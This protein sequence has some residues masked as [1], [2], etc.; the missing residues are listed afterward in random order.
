MFQEMELEEKTPKE[1][2]LFVQ[3]KHTLWKYQSE[4]GVARR[5]QRF[6]SLRRK[7]ADSQELLSSRVMQVICGGFQEMRLEE[8]RRRV[9]AGTRKG[10][11]RRWK[12]NVV[13]NGWNASTWTLMVK[14]TMSGG[15]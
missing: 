7:E 14:V 12:P 3:K 11:Q 2:M 8:E 6:G 4:K 1:A 15:K 10:K 9:G 13:S 5:L